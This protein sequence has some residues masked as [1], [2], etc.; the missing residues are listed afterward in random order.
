VA[1]VFFYD[2]ELCLKCLVR[3]I[4]AKRTVDGSFFYAKKVYVVFNEGDAG[5]A[6][7]T[8]ITY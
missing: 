5:S 1:C 2:K 6:E 4:N 3:Y 7:K 8:N